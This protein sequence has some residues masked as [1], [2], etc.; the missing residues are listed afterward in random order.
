MLNGYKLDKSK[1]NDLVVNLRIGIVKAVLKC[2]Y[3]LVFVTKE[4]YS[5][6]KEHSSDKKIMRKRAKMLDVLNAQKLLDKPMETRSLL[7]ITTRH[8]LPTD[9]VKY[10]SE[11]VTNSTTYVNQVLK[12]RRQV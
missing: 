4:S 11:Y 8:Y 9:L 10:I 2:G 6:I 1:F 7:L 3:R 12:L 5:T